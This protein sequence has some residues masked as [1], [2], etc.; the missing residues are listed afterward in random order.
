MNHFCWEIINEKKKTKIILTNYSIEEIHIGI[1]KII[2]SKPF[3]DE[4][5][6]IMRPITEHCIFSDTMFSYTNL[7]ISDSYINWPIRDTFREV[8]F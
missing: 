7:K 8:I 4:F 3:P 6:S 5:L 2:T 1:T